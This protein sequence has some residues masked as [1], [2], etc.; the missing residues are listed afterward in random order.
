MSIAKLPKVASQ[1]E[2]QLKPKP[3]K[4]AVD[5][6]SKEVQDFIEIRPRTAAKRKYKLKGKKVVITLTMNPDDL[7]RVNEVAA[8]LGMTRAALLNMWIQQQLKKGAVP[9]ETIIF[10]SK[11]LVKD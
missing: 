8:D 7:D 1:F 2:E 5:F 10:T 11:L 6:N 4:K 3:E 9:R